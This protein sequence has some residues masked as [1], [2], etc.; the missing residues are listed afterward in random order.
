MTLKTAIKKRNAAEI[1]KITKSL[2]V[3]DIADKLEL[4]TTEEQVVFFRLLNTSQQAEIFVAL[5]PK[6]QEMLIHAFNDNDLGEIIKDLYSDDLADIV[7]EVPSNLA[8]RIIKVSSKETRSNINKLLRYE[9]NET[10]SRM[11]TDIISLK[12]SY[13]LSKAK[14]IIKKEKHDAEIVHY[15]YVTD[16]KGKLVGSITIEDLLFNK[17]TTTIKSI[18]KPTASVTTKTDVEEAANKFADHN[19]SVMPVINSSGYLAGMI[20]SDDVIDIIHEEATE[21]IEKM[22]GITHSDTEKDKS[23]LAT[24]AW[25]IF[26]KRVIWL[27]LLMISATVSQI[28]LDAFQGISIAKLDSGTKGATTAIFTTAIVA[29]LPVISGAAGNAGSQSST[30]I[31]RSLATGDISTKDYLKVFGKEL[32]VST[33]TGITLGIANFARLMIYYAVKGQAQDIE[34]IALAGA[35][36][37]S[38]FAVIVLAKVVGG[39]L[40]ILAKKVKLDPAVMAAPLLTT[41]IDALSTMIFFS[42]SIGILT[43]VV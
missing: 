6:Y 39:M 41:I 2:P 5:E 30:T 26:L 38:L 32:Q 23:Y 9:E 31:I 10:G 3:A 25:R 4:M 40:P 34:Y 29:I 1:R 20:T 37:L 36:S 16:N 28:V 7:E 11:S 24:P 19:R 21:D 42:I 18:M 22:A 35:A 15:F 14:E 17:G 12:Q 43:L 27:M 13:T 33:I 8:T